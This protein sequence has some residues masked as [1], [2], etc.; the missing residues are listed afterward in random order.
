MENNLIKLTK[1]KLYDICDK[2]DIIQYK[3]KTKEELIKIIIDKNPKEH[4]NKWVHWTYKSTS[5]PFKSTESGIGS[6]ERKLSKELDIN[7]KGQNSCY[8]LDI[9]IDGKKY[10]ADVKKLDNNTFNVGVIGK[11]KIRDIKDKLNNLF[12]ICKK[13]CNNSLI[14]LTDIEHE[15]IQDI[16]KIN[17][18]EISSN[19]IVKIRELLFI[20]YTK[21]EMIKNNLINKEIYDII[22]GNLIHTNI[23]TIYKILI[24]LNRTDIEIQCIIGG[25]DNL[26]Q[27]KCFENF[28]HCYIND[29][30]L[31]DIDICNIKNIFNDSVLIFVDEVKGY[32]IMTEPYMKI[33]FNRITRGSPRFKVHFEI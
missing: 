31:F 22:T 10:K 24:L 9:I 32:Y 5:I 25:E 15:M 17:P 23:Y 33:V 6:G 27:V 16:T 2:L 13:I 26:T 28:D 1:K 18:D 7:I 29:Y 30:K 11:S 14:T 19:N 20:L 8:D 21:K 12:L 4:N 3:S